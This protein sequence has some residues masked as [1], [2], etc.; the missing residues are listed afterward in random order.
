MKTAKILL[1]LTS[2]PRIGKK[3][4]LNL[5]LSLK[6]KSDDQNLLYEQIRVYSKEYHKFEHITEAMI[7]GAL[8]STESLVEETL[9]LNCQ[10][11]SIFDNKYPSRLRHIDNPPLVLFLKGNLEAI[12]NDKVG[13]LIGTRKPNKFGL[14]SAHKVGCTM[15]EHSITVVSGLALGC[16]TAGHRGCLEK[17][18]IGIGVLAHGLD[19]IYPNASKHLSESLLEAGGLL[20]TEYPL[21]TKPTKYTFVERDRLQSGLSDFVFIA[22]TNEKGGTMHTVKFTEAQKRPL[23]CLD[24]PEHA[25]QEGIASGNRML[26]KEQRASPYSI[27]AD[28]SD[29]LN[30]VYDRRGLAN[31]S[32]KAFQGQRAFEFD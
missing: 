14:D 25:Y 28:F 22:E 27:D 24:F 16:D 8:S 5:F 17:N 2:L 13:A 1:S 18:G 19:M 26:I 31:N 21:K 6:E 10:I 9:S 12:S 23:F 32:E 15:A 30:S 11:I 20:V 7:A 29:I 3:T 4:A